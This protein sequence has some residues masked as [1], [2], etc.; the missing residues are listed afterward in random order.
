MCEEMKNSCTKDHDLMTAKFKM[1]TTHQTIPHCSI[2]EEMT[3]VSKN[4]QDDLT[5]CGLRGP[6]GQSMN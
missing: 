3:L 5:I 6:S 4:Y 1:K 2:K